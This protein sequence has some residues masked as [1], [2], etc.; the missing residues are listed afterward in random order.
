MIVEINNIRF[1]L[2]PTD[3]VLG[4]IHTQIIELL[5]ESE[6]LDRFKQLLESDSNSAYSIF[7]AENNLNE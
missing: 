7:V 5:K 6:K 2:N 3:E 4:A 1:Y